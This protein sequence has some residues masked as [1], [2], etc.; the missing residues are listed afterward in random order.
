MGMLVPSLSF[1]FG[2]PTPRFAML[3]FTILN[4]RQVMPIGRDSFAEENFD[5]GR[6]KTILVA[7]YRGAIQNMYKI[8]KNLKLKID[9]T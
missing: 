1:K 4:T 2:I 6:Y 9:P 3:L 5:T 8:P 7:I